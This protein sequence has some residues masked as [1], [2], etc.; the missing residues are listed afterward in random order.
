MING[1]VCSVHGQLDSSQIRFYGHGQTPSGKHRISKLCKPCNR[2]RARKWY[3]DNRER[4][5]EGAKNRRRCLRLL[6]LNAYGHECA[7][8]GESRMEFLTIDHVNGGGN[9]H[10]REM[11]KSGTDTTAV[12]RWLKRNGFPKDGFQCLCQNCNSAKAFFGYCP[13]TG[14]KPGQTPPMPQVKVMPDEQVQKEAQAGNVVP[15]D[16]A[17]RSMGVGA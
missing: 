2:D 16:Q 9:A 5:N 3:S 15:I 6:V 17:R 7:C 12:L 13:H 1:S 10:R 14:G 11:G 4:G 8:C